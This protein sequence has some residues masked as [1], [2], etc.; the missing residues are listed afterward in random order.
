MTDRR[1]LSPFQFVQDPGGALRLAD[2]PDVTL[3]TIAEQGTVEGRPWQQELGLPYSFE[4]WEALARLRTDRPHG[5]VT[6]V[7]MDESPT[8]LPGQPR[9]RPKQVLVSP[10]CAL[11]LAHSGFVIGTVDA[12]VM[13]IDEGRTTHPAWFTV[14][15]PSDLEGD[16]IV[17]H[18]RFFDSAMAEAAQEGLARGIFTHVCPVLWTPTGAVLGTGALVQVSLVPGDFPGCPRA[19]VLDWSAAVGA[20][21]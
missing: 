1:H 7:L 18:A 21:P 11:E 15:L 6:F 17:G 4:E 19:R 10:V 5:E 3:H 2:F 8:R 14:P 20:A 9:L 13:G 12:Y 16:V